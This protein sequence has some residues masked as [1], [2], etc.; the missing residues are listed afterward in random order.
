MQTQ[1]A[2][3]FV[4]DVAGGGQSDAFSVALPGSGTLLVVSSVLAIGGTSPVLTIYL[5]DL[6]GGQWVQA[7][8]LSAQS[9]VG[10]ASGTAGSPGTLC[11][12][13]WTLSGTG[14]SAQIVLCA[15][16]E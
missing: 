15:A 13:R 16:G 12:F 1:L 4:A 11:R 3:T 7:V 6:Q 10:V 2:P 8:A 9:G 14:A 5:D